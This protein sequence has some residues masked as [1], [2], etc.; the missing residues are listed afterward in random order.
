MYMDSQ[1]AVRGCGRG[2]E[3]SS[4]LRSAQARM[5]DVCSAR[6]N[7]SWLCPAAPNA[8][9]NAIQITPQLTP[10]VPGKKERLRA[11]VNIPFWMPLHP[12]A[13]AASL[14]CPGLLPL[15]WIQPP[16]GPPLYI[17]HPA[18]AWPPAP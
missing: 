15:P 14:P 6:R 18:L 13:E 16:A 9:A 12:R 11:I 2:S 10:G 17:P 5:E 3:R 1:G 7:C 4:A 8:L